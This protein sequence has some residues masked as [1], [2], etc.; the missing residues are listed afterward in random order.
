MSSRNVQN[1]KLDEKVCFNCKNL[2]WKIGIGLGISCHIRKG[3]KI[4]SIKSYTCEKF[5]YEV[6]PVK[7]VE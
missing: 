7:K 3:F 5:Q 2:A 4:P 1:P 6:E